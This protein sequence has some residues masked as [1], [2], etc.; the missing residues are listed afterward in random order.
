VE[1]ALQALAER[2]RAAGA[3]QARLRIRGGGTKDFYGGPLEGDVLDTQ[4][5]AGII[6][7]EPNELVITARAGTSLAA[8][9]S[10]MRARG[11]MLAFEPPRF[12]AGGTLGG[13]IASGLSG[14][15]RPYAGAARDL[16]LGIKVLDGAGEHLAFGGQVMKNVAGFD[17]SRLMT[18]ALGTLG[19]ITEV[20]LKCLPMPR[21][22]AT[23][24][25][26]CS[27]DESIRRSNEWGGQPLPLSATCFHGGRLS[28]R[29]SGARPAVQ[30]AVARLGGQAQSDAGAFWTSV[31]DHAHP[32]FAE[33]AAQRRPLW[34]LSVRS[35]AP[36]TDLGGEQLIEWG[37]ALR[38]LAAGERIDADRVRGWAAS[39]GGHA[40]LFRAD[41][42]TA[43]VFH[44]LE[45]AIA[46]IHRKLKAVFDPHDVFNHG[47]FV[48]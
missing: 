20:S 38:W 35:T 7:Y 32:F 39:Q 21:E 27:A 22:E 28:V 42:K 37:G 12:A 31:R 1:P 16:V 5:Y 30:A 3:S 8:V 43:A 47:R 44:P 13:A 14:P 9:E 45:P 36:Y 34:R 2:I 19:V 41:D 24:A 10:A 15:R 17:V 46:E 11:Q 18:G 26:E 23:V 40:T 25:F 33:A 29:L 4:V 48:Q 6:D